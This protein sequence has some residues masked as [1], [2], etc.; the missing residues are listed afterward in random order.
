[1]VMFGPVSSTEHSPGAVNH[2]VAACLLEGSLQADGLRVTGWR[3]GGKPLVPLSPKQLL[4]RTIGC[5]GTA[6]PGGLGKFKK[7]L[8]VHLT[9][10]LDVP[11]E[12]LAR[13]RQVN[14]WYP[15]ALVAIPAQ[16]P[17]ALAHT[18]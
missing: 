10:S 2:R 8:V 13:I 11:K 7:K 17:T 3:K 16:F 5:A 14:G 4:L 18:R 12:P 15:T 9:A 1:V 6:A